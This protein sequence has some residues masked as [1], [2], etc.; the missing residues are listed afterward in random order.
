MSFLFVTYPM[1]LMTASFLFLLGILLSTFFVNLFFIS[2]VIFLLYTDCLTIVPLL[3]YLEVFLT[4]IFQNYIP[5][6]KKNIQKVFP[7]ESKG[8]LKQGIYLFHPHG[9]FSIAHA[10]H[11]GSTMTE[12]PVKKIK[13]TVHSL[14]T[15]CPIIKDLI[16][17]NNTFVPSNYED[18]KNVLEN[19]KSLSVCLGGLNE[20]KYTDMYKMIVNIKHRKGVFRMSLETGIPLV[21]VISY[22]ENQV[23]QRIENPLISYLESVVGLRI[24]IPTL[25]S[26][27]QWLS[28]VKRPL[29]YTIPTYIGEA[30]N[31][32]EAHIP[33]NNEIISLRERYFVALKKLYLETRP[34][35]YTEDIEII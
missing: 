9:L 8:G 20:S 22:N 30:L 24:N 34:E 14:L 35:T 7:V 18:M 3:R 4:Y 28:I 31:V 11:V 2:F 29:S 16:N 23:Y 33:K 27:V 10:F 17:Y 1:S 6:I 13:G 15:S 32:G 5:T 26:V 25:A 21:P 12:W 19:G